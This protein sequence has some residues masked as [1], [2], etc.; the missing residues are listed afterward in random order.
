MKYEHVRICFKHA[1]TQVCWLAGSL[2][3]RFNLMLPQASSSQPNTVYNT[4]SLST[5]YSF[6]IFTLQLHISRQHLA[7]PNPNSQSMK[8]IAPGSHYN[9]QYE[10]LRPSKQHEPCHWLQG[11]TYC[12]RYGLLVESTDDVTPCDTHQCMAMYSKN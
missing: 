2:L 1:E 9:R 6:H 7:Q 8:N 10:D 12:C 4:S 3:V 11:T 5:Y